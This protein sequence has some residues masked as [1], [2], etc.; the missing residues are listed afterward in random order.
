MTLKEMCTRKKKISDSADKIRT[1][2][3]MNVTLG[4]ARKRGLISVAKRP[5]GFI[6]AWLCLEI[7]WQ[8]EIWW[9]PLI[10]EK[11]VRVLMNDLNKK[12]NKPVCVVFFLIFVLLL[13]S[14]NAVLIVSWWLCWQHITTYEHCWQFG[15]RGRGYIALDTQSKTGRW[16]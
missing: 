15:C 14:V 12:I 13:C 5:R 1:D 8:L 9:W 2:K 4:K 7:Q 11:M 3:M 16:L 6:S 10:N